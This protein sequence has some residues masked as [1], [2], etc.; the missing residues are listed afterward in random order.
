VKGGDRMILT[1]ID[2]EVQES[3]KGGAGSLVQFNIAGGT[4]DGVRAQ[5]FGLPAFQV[6]EDVLLFLSEGY[7]RTGAPIVGVNQG[8]F[9][10][11]NEGGGEMMLDADSHYVIGVENDRVM[12]RR[13]PGAPLA[14]SHRIPTILGPP[15]PDSPDVVVSASRA[16]NRFW[17]SQEPAMGL[18]AF[19]DAVA[20]RLGR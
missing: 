15:V 1:A 20:A 2:L 12:T 16:A 19:K 5:V 13:N 8:A 3:I 14:S 10:I 7:Q 17:T 4:V 9:R 11:V 6:N 18:A